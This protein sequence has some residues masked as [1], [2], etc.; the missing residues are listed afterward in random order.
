[1]TQ[2]A[3]QLSQAMTM[4]E[5]LDY[6]DGTDTRYELV[7]GELI[8]MTTESPENCKLAKLLMLELSKHISIV[9]IN[10]KDLEV[11]VSGRR[12]TVRLPDLAIM[13]EE[14][15]DALSVQRSKYSHP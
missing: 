9:L 3:P 11:A 4:A 8:E 15:Y 2:A 10:M 5:Y 12:A 6:D 13:S 7:D 1:M 14:G